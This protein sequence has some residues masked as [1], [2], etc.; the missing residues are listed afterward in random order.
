ME[1]EKGREKI[2]EGQRRKG[3]GKR[4]AERGRGRETREAN[5]A[6]VVGDGRHPPGDISYYK[7]RQ[8]LITSAMRY[9]CTANIIL[10]RRCDAKI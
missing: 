1:R 5:G 7:R 8:L 9:D 10:R 2:G 6:L 4:R 3:E